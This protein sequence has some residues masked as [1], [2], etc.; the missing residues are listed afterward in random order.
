MLRFPSYKMGMGSTM[1]ISQNSQ[2]NEWNAPDPKNMLD[3]FHMPHPPLMWVD[4]PATTK[5]K[6]EH[7]F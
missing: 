1:L 3:L 2:H 5:S 7:N 4:L 6:E